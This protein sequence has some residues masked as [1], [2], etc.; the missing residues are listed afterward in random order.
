LI[1]QLSFFGT[2]IRKAIHFPS[3]DQAMSEGD[4]SS[5]VICV[6][7]PSASIQ[8]TKICVP[9]GSP[10]ARKAM[11]VPS[12]DQRGEEPSI[13]CRARLPSAFM[14]QSD[15]AHRSLILSTHR[16][17]KTIWLPSGESCGS[18]TLSHSR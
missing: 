4:S 1:G 18:A 9:R 17:V 14:I 11:R 3:G 8:R 13:R 7:A 6:T 16:R 15:E 5:R 12:G 2:S 10:R